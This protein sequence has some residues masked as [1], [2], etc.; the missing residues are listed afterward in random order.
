VASATTIRDAN[1]ILL[2]IAPGY[3]RA[4]RQSALAVANLESGFGVSGSWLLDDG[5]PS[6]NS[7]AITCNASRKGT[8]GCFSHGDVT[9]EGAPTTYEFMAFNTMREG[10]QAFIGTWGRADTLAAASRGDA[11]GVAAA[12]YGHGY[13]TGSKGSDADRINAYAAAILGSAGSIASALGEP[14]SV[15][16]GG[17]SVVSAVPWWGWPIVIALV[18]GIFYRV[19]R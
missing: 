17:S 7:G 12:M 2:S 9:A 14:M 6:Y 5:T 3:N 13:Y 18:G 16:A 8:A 4:Q 10:L 19:I 11:H 15:S 1:A